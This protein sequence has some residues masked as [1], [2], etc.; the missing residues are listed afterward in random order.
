[1]S[2][3]MISHNIPKIR[4]NIIG[5]DLFELYGQKYLLAIDY[6]SKFIE[7]KTLQKGTTSNT[8]IDKLKSMFARY[9]IPLTVVTDGGPQFFS[10]E[11]KHFSNAWEFNHILTS[12]H[13]AQSNGM[14]ERNVQTLKGIFK[15]VLEDKRKYLALLQYR[16]IDIN[17]TYSPAEILMSRKLRSL[18]PL[19]SKNLKPKLVDANKYDSFL[20][21]R[22]FINEKYFNKKGTQCLEPLKKQ[23]KSIC[24]N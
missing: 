21:H 9:G 22:Q 14:A 15:K 20:N 2:E 7:I 11:F 13:Y 6:Y 10:G 24:S 18:L 5:C 8:I 19:K 16:N 1:M 17:G 12:P 4:W 3:T 23:Y